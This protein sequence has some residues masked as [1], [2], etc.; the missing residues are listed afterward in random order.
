MATPTAHPSSTLATLLTAAALLATLPPPAPLPLLG[1]PA[2]TA[3]AQL[4]TARFAGTDSVITRRTF[5]RYTKTLR[6][7]A[8]QTDAANQLFTAY[9]D[10]AAEIDRAA[11]EKT[12]E[13]RDGIEGGGAAPEGIRELIAKLPEITRTASKQHADLTTPFLDDIRSLLTPE[14][15][16]RWAALERLRRREA[17]LSSAA[18]LG[19]ASGSNLDLTVVVD[20]LKLPD[21]QTQAIAPALEAYEIELDA[22]L[23][24]INQDDQQWRAD[25]A[26]QQGRP[27]DGAVIISSTNTD[28]FLAFQ[29]SSRENALRLRDLNTKHLRQ[30]AAAL[31]PEW[32]Q[33]LTDAYRR[34]AFPQIFRQSNATRALAAAEAFKDLTDEQRTAIAEIRADYAARLPALNQRWLSELE[35][36]EAEGKA[37]PFPLPGMGQDEAKE[38]ADARTARREFDK[39][40]TDKLTALLTPAQR[41]R[42]PKPG[43]PASTAGALIGTTTGGGPGAGGMVIQIG[44]PGADDDDNDE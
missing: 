10:R 42:L 30:T 36:A 34:R 21:E 17:G 41:D 4:G 20:S 5:D 23:S 16:T 19:G 27:D 24:Q 9:A 43:R 40:F 32:G 1:E 11:E 18:P 26:K 44:P 37:N 22:V 7:D 6:L 25:R 8:A 39:A 3:S 29:K 12:R 14:Q 13:L 31:G 38:L 2:A 33:K 28:D 15:E 35:R